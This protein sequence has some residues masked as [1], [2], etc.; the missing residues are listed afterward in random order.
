MYAVAQGR[1]N[2]ITSPRL[3]PDARVR[4][5]VVRRHVRRINA[6]ENLVSRYE[7]SVMNRVRSLRFCNRAR[8][9][10]FQYVEK[11]KSVRRSGAAKRSL[12]ASW[13]EKSRERYFS[14]SAKITRQRITI[15]SGRGQ[16]GRVT[17]FINI[18]RTIDTNI[19]DA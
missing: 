8:G 13:I 15:I 18:S 16:R 19:F 4:R 5:R 14:V 7:I 17:S 3:F 10:T 12:I 2:C 11:K 6:R 9:C 1:D